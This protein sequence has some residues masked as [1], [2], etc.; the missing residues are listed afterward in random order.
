MQSKI[1]H[2]VVSGAL[3]VALSATVATAAEMNSGS[4]V[5]LSVIG[6]NISDVDFN[7]GKGSTNSASLDTAKGVMLRGGRDMGAVRAELEL[8]Y[9]KVDIDGV[10][11][12][13]AASGDSKLYTAMINAAYDFDT[14]S[15]VTPY[16]SAGIGA[17]RATG[18]IAYSDTDGDAVAQNFSG[19]AVAGQVGLGIGYAV[20][21]N[22]NIVGGY[23]FLAAPTKSN[24]DGTIKM[25]SIQLGLNYNF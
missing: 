11:T 8:G 22:V 13:T 17:I 19:T 21:S 20:S 10:K 23:S 1:I 15:A 24:M 5:G 2:S 25:H 18:N 4:Y 3:A 12:G 14:D 6:S 9:R 7:N 16:I